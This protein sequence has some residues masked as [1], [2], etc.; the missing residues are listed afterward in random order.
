MFEA[1]LAQSAQL[2]AA[3]G[4]VHVGL[5]E[6]P[7]VV[8]A[9]LAQDLPAGHEGPNPKPPVSFLEDSAQSPQV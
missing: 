6:V 3:V 8:A 9:A 7:Q 1:V 2:V 4:F 5:V